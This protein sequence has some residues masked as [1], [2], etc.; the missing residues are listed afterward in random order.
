MIIKTLVKI[1]PIIVA[2]SLLGACATPLTILRVPSVQPLA[3]SDLTNAK[4]LADSS[5]DVD[6]SACYQDL[7]DF[8]GSSTGLPS[9]PKLGGAFSALET[10][11]I[12]R[13]VAS[14]PIPPKLH[15]DCAVLVLDAQQVMAQLGIAVGSVMVA[16]PLLNPPV[17]P[18]GVKLP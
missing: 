1:L 8:V 18:P 9:N 16:K 13:R 15:K 17:L 5:G 10:A 11:R 12:A 6:A 4:A 3:I 2:T 7:L 14:Q